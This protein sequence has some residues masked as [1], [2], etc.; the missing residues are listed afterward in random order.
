MATAA[1][2]LRLVGRGGELAQLEAEL[3]RAIAGELRCVLL[4]ADPGVG[5]TRLAA[6]L[7]NRHQRTVIGLSAR[8]Y[9]LGATASFGLWMEAFERHLS[10]LPPA[11]IRA[12]CGGVLDDLA[13]VLRSVASV[14]GR[15][16]SHETL[17]PRLVQGF[18]VLLRNLAEKAPVVVVLDDVHL[19]DAS[20]LEALSQLARNLSTSRVLIVLAAR[21]AELSQH[22]IAHD[23]LLGLEQDGILARQQL[24]GLSR[25]EVSE[26]AAGVL[27]RDPPAVF[28]D[29]LFTRSRGYPLFALG[30]VRT[31]VEEGGDLTAPTLERVPEELSD[32]VMSGLKQLD[33]P[34]LSTLEVLAV[35]GRRVE[36]QE[37]VV[38]TGRP[39]D[40]LAPILEG[41]VRLR[42][43]TEEE[44][45]RD[46]VYEVTHPLVEETIYQAIG[47]ARRRAIHRL[48]ARA[49]AS[50]GQR[51]A[52]ASHYVRCA[53]PGEEEA[54]DAL[55]D[56][57]QQ[58]EER[59]SYREAMPILN[60][61][62]DLLPA[63]DPRWR[64]VLDAMSWDAE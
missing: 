43:L 41:L 27:E 49:F 21:P 4:L 8:A 36:L 2:R 58:A 18:A 37:L 1:T 46:L 30:L 23:V 38:L 20:S 39:L 34:S 44:R 9:P 35:V 12:L 28:T 16:P 45:G 63:G 17:H 47:G 25:D 61:L 32:R 40:R 3:R 14:R 29:W 15:L 22:P 54:I 19:A 51:A 26:L 10:R 42:L 7:L 59:Q 48:L 33:E 53:Q 62:L 50:S 13:S 5:K 24:T 60:G 6:E 11:E 57:L 52:A 31:I 64:R 55:I 56:A